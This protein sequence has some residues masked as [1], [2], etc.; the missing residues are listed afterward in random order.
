MKKENNTIF[1][2]II[3][4]LFWSSAFAAVK[5][6]LKYN[7]PLQFAGIRFMISGLL[8]IPFTLKN[9]GYFKLV[10][11]NFPFILL[12]SLL[13]VF[14]LY[15]LFYHGM[16]LVPGAIG[17]III[18]S[19]PLF[20]AI[21]SHFFMKNDKLSTK[22]MGVMLL[23]FLGIVV[24]TLGRKS[25]DNTSHQLEFIGII[26]LLL[27][28]ILGGFGNIVI[29]S[30][31]TKLPALMLSSTSLFFGG[32]GLFLIAIPIEKI[33]WGPFP[34]SYWTSLVW[35]STLSAI[36]LSIWFLLLKRPGVKVSS[37]NM[38]KFLIPVTG[39]L[40][41]WLLIP[42]E[43]PEFITVIGMILTGTSLILITQ[44]DKKSKTKP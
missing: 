18:G 15:A 40:L 14:G 36:S 20:I 35:L 5:I 4:C 16:N 8:L 19:G 39:A 44:V 11:K 29:A 28:N 31:K 42:D 34:T 38:W 33:H 27:C 22:K 1:L 2:A 17:A 3:A 10:I 12:V 6:G 9:K 43:T 30:S 13:N 37:L 7:A 26:I 25:I 32:L 41:S 23:G 24:V 21:L